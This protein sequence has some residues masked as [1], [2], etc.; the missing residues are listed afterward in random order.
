MYMYMQFS[1]FF[2]EECEP[3]TAVAANTTVVSCLF[4]IKHLF[5]TTSAGKPTI[6][7]QTYN[8]LNTN[9]NLDIHEDDQSFVK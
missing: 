4:G 8:V 5:F 9:G 2:L 6:L 1:G 7:R 3:Y